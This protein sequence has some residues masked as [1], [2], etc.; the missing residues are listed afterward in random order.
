MRLER[1]HWP[2]VTP[3]PICAGLTK[4]GGI[5]RNFRYR[6]CT[7][8]GHGIKDVA[9]AWTYSRN[10]EFVVIPFDQLEAEMGRVPAKGSPRKSGA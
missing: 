3:C 2:P 8:C 6:N 1:P 9:L 7:E 10:G 5:H 4:H